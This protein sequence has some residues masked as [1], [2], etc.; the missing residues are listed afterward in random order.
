MEI[1][2]YDIRTL[3]FN[4]SEQPNLQ[5]E[6]NRYMKKEEVYSRLLYSTYST[7]CCLRMGKPKWKF[8]VE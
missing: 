5:L 6:T 8:I 3:L 4:F 2:A 7:V 1:T